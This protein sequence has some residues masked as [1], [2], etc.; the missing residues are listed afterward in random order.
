MDW[1]PRLHCKP[2]RAKVVH[3]RAHDMS[4]DFFR[5]SYQR[6][7]CID[8]IKDICSST[9]LPNLRCADLNHT[10]NQPPLVEQAFWP[11]PFPFVIRTLHGLR[12]SSEVC[13]P[14]VGPRDEEGEWSA[15]EVNRIRTE[16]RRDLEGELQVRRRRK[17]YQSVYALLYSYV[18]SFRE[19]FLLYA[20]PFLNHRELRKN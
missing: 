16:I 8:T 13:S 12:I 3:I 2:C 14:E 18:L 1:M 17:P 11:R 9:R 5:I 20:Q 7:C 10:R 4:W 15:S 6:S 19:Y